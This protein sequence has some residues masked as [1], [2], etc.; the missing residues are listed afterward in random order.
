[1]KNFIAEFKQF[2]MRG[3]VIDLAVGVV[4]GTAFGKIVSSLVS[5]IIMPLIGLV[6]GKINFTALKLGPIAVGNFI[7]A[8]ID[9]IIVAF[10]IFVAVKAINRLNK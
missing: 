7:Q 8:S 5:D 10:V 6:L 1:M 4:I 2:A 3:N 9:F